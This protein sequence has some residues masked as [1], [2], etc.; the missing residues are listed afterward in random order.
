M[1]DSVLREQRHRNRGNPIGKR[2]PLP[3]ENENDHDQDCQ[4]VCMAKCYAD[5]DRQPEQTGTIGLAPEF[6][7]IIFKH[8]SCGIGSAALPPSDTCGRSGI[9]D[10][11]VWFCPVELCTVVLSAD[12]V[13]TGTL[14]DVY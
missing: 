10:R 2:F 6:A 4:S 7:E 14:H 13:A 3:F 1:V 9:A 5:S 12:K 11:S 8:E